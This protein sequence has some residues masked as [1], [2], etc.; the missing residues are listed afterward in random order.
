M[1]IETAVLRDM[2]GVNMYEYISNIQ[3]SPVQIIL[4]LILTCTA[5]RQT[6]HL[7]SEERIEYTYIVT[8][9]FNCTHQSKLLNLYRA[10]TY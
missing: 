1:H 9:E 3:A 4:I 8:V 2:H 10:Y 6:Q 5:L 7:N